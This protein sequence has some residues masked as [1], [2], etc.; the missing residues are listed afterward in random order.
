M[1]DHYSK[2]DGNR[3]LKAPLKEPETL[4]ITSSVQAVDLPE[5]YQ[6]Q[7][8]TLD[9]SLFIIVS[10]GT[11]REKDYFSFFQLNSSKF[12]RI[13]IEFIYRDDDGNEGLDVD[14]L[15]EASLQIKKQK[16]FSKDADI[17]DSIS[18][19]TDVD[20]FYSQLERNQEVCRNNNLQLIISNPCFEIWL[21]YTHFNTKPDYVIPSEP[22]KISS[23]FKTY[24]NEKKPGGVDP[25]KAPLKIA[26]AINNSKENYVEDEI[27]IPK[28]FSTQMH[29]LAA[30][31]FELTKDDLR[32]H[33][34]E[35]ELRI[36]KFKQ[37]KIGSIANKLSKLSFKE[38]N[39][40]KRKINDHNN[41]KE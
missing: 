21:Y 9:P 39:D 30:R 36:L 3:E 41:K 28:I 22:L 34:K 19:V 6:K 14:K 35:E 24:L 7:E 4:K 1:A 16:E 20:H 37:G 29:I 5:D 27:G 8:G 11:V 10:G 31:I 2:T 25:R 26:D 38:V 13:K 40:L 32:I 33:L 15:V 18:L 17:I 23:G 12:P